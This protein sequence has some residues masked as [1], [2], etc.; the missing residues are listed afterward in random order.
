MKSR[1]FVSILILVF[2]I[3]IV[4]GSCATQKKTITE[5]DFLDAWTGTWVNTDIPGGIVIPQKFIN[6][7][8]GTID[9]YPSA[10]SSNVPFIIEFTLFERWADADGNTWF[11]AQKKWE[12]DDAKIMVHEYVKINRSG[13]TYELIYNVG[14]QQVDD[15]EPDN[16]EYNYLIYYRQ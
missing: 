14:S 12:N 8:D 3:L 5:G 13:D 15:W 7:P 10:V 1:T 6:H 2:S 4:L 11:K 16:P 9:Y